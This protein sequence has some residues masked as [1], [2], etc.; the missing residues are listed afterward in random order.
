M[1]TEP[2]SARDSETRQRACSTQPLELEL[3]ELRARVA[4]IE[5]TLEAVSG[6]EAGAPVEV[7][8]ESKASVAEL[9]LFIG[10]IAHDLRDP[11]TT[12]VSGT[13]LLGRRLLA[14][15]EQRV[16]ERIEAAA[17][18]MTRMIGHVLDFARGRLGGGI[19]IRRES[20]DLHALVRAA[21]A[22]RKTSHP[23]RRIELKL[24]GTG[25]GEWDADRLAQVVSNLL[26]N[27]LEHGDPARPVRVSSFD[28]NGSLHL[29]V[30]NDGTQIPPD[31]LPVIFDP[32]RRGAAGLGTGP[33]GVGL[34]L[35]I[36]KQIVH[37]H[38]G[39]LSVESTRQHGTKFAVVLPRIART[40][41]SGS[42]AR[43]G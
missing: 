30:Q 16:V 9:E 26:G 27:A 23:D 41:L 25:T 2:L 18:R 36:A 31:L 39:T 4:E 43:T 42:K 21:V 15:D 7:T 37:A 3:S 13:H 24:E 6:S 38:G 40:C 8:S 35:H 34:G 19:P 32:F 29:E 33:R 11:L 14:P 17:A 20:G 5:A 10:M 1:T 12:I 28:E 22:D